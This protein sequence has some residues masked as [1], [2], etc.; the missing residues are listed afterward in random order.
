MPPDLEML[1]LGS[2]FKIAEINMTAFVTLLRAVNVAGTGKLAMS[3]VKRL[4]EKAG[5]VD[6]QTYIASGNA[7]FRSEKTE[8][9]V[10]ATLGASL[11]AYAG[12][13]I[14]VVV[15]TA[16]EIAAIVAAN[17]FPAVIPSRMLV[18]F[19]DEPPPG[20]ALDIIVGRNNEEIRLG[21]REIYVHYIDGVGRSKLK[22]PAARSGTARN[23]NTV[24]KL[25]GLA[26]EL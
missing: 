1:N 4:C 24:A 22:I 3:D 10:K 23:M 19:L 12:K 2:R 25:A 7:I 6:V 20:D 16:A 14:G 13:A 11:E 5:L 15:R 26:L 8:A 21:K 9:E 17:P 18:I